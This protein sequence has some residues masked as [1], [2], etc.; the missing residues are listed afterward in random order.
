MTCALKQSIFPIRV[1]RSNHVLFTVLGDCLWSPDLWLNLTLT[2]YE[3]ICSNGD[4]F[5]LL[6]II[7]GNCTSNHLS[8][9]KSGKSLVSDKEKQIYVKGNRSFDYRNTCILLHFSVITRHSYLLLDKKNIVFVT[10]IV[11]YHLRK[12]Y[13]KSFIMG[14]TSLLKSKYL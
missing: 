13:V 8:W 9:T 10:V 4:E 1:E 5:A 3:H 7:W 6:F 11:I 2:V 12:L 14:I